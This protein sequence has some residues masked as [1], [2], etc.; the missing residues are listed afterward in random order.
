MPKVKVTQVEAPEGMFVVTKP[1]ERKSYL[2]GWEKHFQDKGI[3][4]QI[5]QDSKQKYYLCREGVEV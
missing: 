5:I 3:R 2:K 4:T 1:M